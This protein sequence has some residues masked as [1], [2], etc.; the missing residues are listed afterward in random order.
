MTPCRMGGD[1]TPGGSHEETLLDEEWLVDVLDGL[2]WFG[3]ADR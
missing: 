2:P 3:H 1:T